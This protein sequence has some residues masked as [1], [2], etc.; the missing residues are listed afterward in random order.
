MT[1]KYETLT[2]ASEIRKTDSVEQKRTIGLTTRIYSLLL[3][4]HVWPYWPSSGYFIFIVSL[5]V[6]SYTMDNE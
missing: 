6:I 1:E 3:S 5:T 4:Q 2:E